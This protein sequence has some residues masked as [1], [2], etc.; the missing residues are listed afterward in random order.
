MRFTPSATMKKS[1]GLVV[2][3]VFLS[4]SVSTQVVSAD[5]RNSNVPSRR[6][7][8]VKFSGGCTQNRE[9]PGQLVMDEQYDPAC[10]VTTTIT[11]TTE[12]IVSLQ[13]WDEEDEKWYEEARKRTTKRKATLNINAENCGENNDEYCDGTYEYRIFVLPSTRPRLGAIKSLPF[14]VVFVSLDGGDDEYDEDYCDPDLE[15]C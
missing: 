15:Y 8:S 3:L 11:G 6:I 7:S 4:T 12:R 14:E 10:R 1:C 13:W 9:Y 5:S 2:A